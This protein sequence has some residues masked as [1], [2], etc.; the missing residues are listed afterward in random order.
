MMPQPPGPVPPPSPM[1]RRPMA[2]RINKCLRVLSVQAVRSS[3]GSMLTMLTGSVQ[4]ERAGRYT[5]DS[6][7]R[8]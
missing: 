3:S 1:L 7:Y 6:F 8:K 4:R 2:G 5:D